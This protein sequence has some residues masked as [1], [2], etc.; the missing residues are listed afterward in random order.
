NKI[1]KTEKEIQDKSRSLY[2]T[3]F[4]ATPKIKG[5]KLFIYLSLKMIDQK[6]IEENFFNDAIIFFKD[7]ITKPNFYNKK[8]D[9]QVLE[10]IKKDISNNAQKIEK[11]PDK[12]Q[13]ILFY[14][15]M[16]PE[17][18]FNYKNPSY[19]EL[20]NIL[21][22]INDQDVIDFYQE[23]IN[24]HIATYTFGNLNDEEN[25]IIK[26][27]FKFNSISFDYSYEHKETLT[28]EYK[29]IKST[30]TTQSYLYVAY[31][32]VDY[33]K[34]NTHIYYALLTMLNNFKGLCHKI[35]RDE[36][37]L[38]YHSYADFLSNRG[39]F[40][41]AAQIDKKNTDK[42]LAGIDEIMQR[43][44]KREFIEEML[45]FAKEKYAQELYTSTELLTSNINQLE[46]YILKYEMLINVL[47]DKINNLTVDDIIKQINNLKKKYIFLYE[48][49]KDE[50]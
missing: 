36:L 46:K 38:V 5:T 31:D 6:I 10:E 44:L 49:D 4:F 34:K 19:E 37:G 33:K 26:D 21:D 41:I 1:Y 40:I 45:A 29:V 43:I 24:S 3:I 23:T 32:I 30:D 15:N 12:F 48:G 35:L 18:Y 28:D 9:S 47:V 11:I 39:I 20:K 16:L 22:N 27:S 7:M 42:A 8:V 17:S 2:R 13:S 14:R 25:Q 50:N